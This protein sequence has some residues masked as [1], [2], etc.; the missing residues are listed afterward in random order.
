MF[1]FFFPQ[2]RDSEGT[3]LA[4]SLFLGFL[5]PLEP[6]SDFW[7]WGSREMGSLDSH[8]PP[9]SPPAAFECFPAPRQIATSDSPTSSFC[10][11]LGFNLCGFSGLAL[12]LSLRFIWWDHSLLLLP[13]RYASYGL[14]GDG[15]ESS[16]LTASVCTAG[17]LS[18]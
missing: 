17:Q 6:F 7:G 18:I 12:V 9:S 4:L 2:T 13:E 5:Q 11:P 15:G 14:L 16:D 1:F 8:P 3:S 10:G